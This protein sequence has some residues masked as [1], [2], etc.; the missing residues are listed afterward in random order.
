ME[1]ARSLAYMRFRPLAG[2]ARYENARK[3]PALPQLRRAQRPVLCH[4]PR[5]TR[6]DTKQPGPP[7][8]GTDSDAQ[9]ERWA[10]Y[11]SVIGSG[12]AGVC[13][14]A[15]PSWT[16]RCATA[17]PKGGRR[18][19]NY[20]IDGCDHEWERRRLWTEGIATRP[21]DVVHRQMYVNFW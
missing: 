2:E 7:K 21:S 11:G 1:G 19:L 12:G 15:R 9:L 18:S 20:V 14:T 3:I 16:T 8:L 17:T 5:A 6:G 13:P 10:V 4:K